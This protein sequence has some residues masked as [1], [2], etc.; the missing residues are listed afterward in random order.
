MAAVELAV[1]LPVFLLVVIGIIEFGR[2]MMVEQLLANCARMGA[3]QAILAGKTNS[4][5]E[6]VVQ[7]FFQKTC[8]ATADITI[9]VNGVANANISTAQRGDLCE[10]AVSVQFS[11]V[12]FLPT[13]SWLSESSLQSRC[14][15]EH[16]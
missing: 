15:M 12:S 16:E 6:N 7:D 2:G 10:V 11:Q 9:S 1:I 8:N 14:T 3:R 4:D 5:I 13:P